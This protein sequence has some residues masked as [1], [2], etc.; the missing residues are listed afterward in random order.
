M[1]KWSIYYLNFFSNV[2]L[3]TRFWLC[4]TSL[5]VLVSFLSLYPILVQEYLVPKNHLLFLYSLSYDRYYYPFHFIKTY[6]G[7]Y[8]FSLNSFTPFDLSYVMGWYNYF[9]KFIKILAFSALLI[10]QLYFQSLSVIEI[11]TNFSL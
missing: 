9:I 8:F 2:V 6:P 10:Q 3:Y 4:H 11:C 1:V 5:F 7:K